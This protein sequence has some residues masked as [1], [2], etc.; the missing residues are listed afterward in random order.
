MNFSN[1]L[2]GHD[3][4]RLNSNRFILKVASALFLASLFAVAV[5]AAEAEDDEEESEIEMTELEEVIVTGSRLERNPGEIAGQ[6]IVL[7]QDAIRAMGE[8]TLERVL[9]QVPQNLNPTSEQFGQRLNTGLN[10]SGASTVNLRGLGSESTLILID[11]KRAGYSGFLGGVTDV[12]KIPLAQVERIEIVLDGASAIYGSDAVGGVVNVITRKDYEGIEAVLNYDRPSTAGY[13]ETRSGINGRTV[14]SGQRLSGGIQVATH[15]GLDASDRDVTI[16]QQSAFAGPRY[17]VRFCC[18]AEGEA[19]PIFYRLGGNAITL[20]EYNALDDAQK[21]QAEAIR[22]VKLPEGFNES[23]SL[24]DITE[25]GPP[26]WG[27]ATQEG[28]SVLPETTRTSF[29]AGIGSDV[30]PDISIEAT[31][32]GENRETLNN[33]GYISYSGQ[34]LNGRNPYNPFARPVHLRGQRRDLPGPY[35]ETNSDSLDLNF[36][37]SG[38]I[39]EQWDWEASIGRTTEESDSSRYNNVNRSALTA[40][41]NSDGVSPITQFLRGETPE[42]CAEKGG[43]PFFGLC[44]IQLPPIPAVNPFGDISEFITEP[45]DATSSNRQ[46]RLQALIRGELFELPGGMAKAMVGASMENTS[47]DSMTEFQIGVVEQSPIGDVSSLN[48]ETERSNSAIFAEGALPL[49]SDSNAMSGVNALHLSLSLRRD[50]Y[51]APDVTFISAD[52]ERTVEDLPE[53]GTETTWGLGVVYEPMTA[54]RLKLNRQ[55]AFVAPQLNQLL[56]ESLQ[57]PSPPFRGIWLQ[58]PDGSIQSRSI[59]VIE[60]GNPNLVPETAVTD[61]FGVEIAPPF[62]PGLVLRSTYSDVEYVDRIGFISAFFID[63]NNLPSNTFYDAEEDIYLQER[64][65]VNVSSVNR[66]G[67]DFEL[68]WSGTNDLGNY[69]ISLKRSVINKYDYV[70]DPAIQEDPLGEKISVVGE[71]TGTTAI[72]V[73]PKNSTSATVTVE[74]FGVETS[75]DYTT[76][77]ETTRSLAGVTSE[78]SAPTLM[79]LTFSMPLTEDFPIPLPATIKGGRISLIINNLG[80]QFGETRIRNAAGMPL[81]QTGTDRSPLYGRTFNLGLNLNL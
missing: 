64:R 75:W 70:I 80:D 2:S 62:A 38:V 63:P 61:S 42:S 52:G 71:T 16:F 50:T 81:E 19:F 55:T 25:F 20:T 32:R 36:D 6:V 34:T 9:R 22:Y 67:V 24:N 40:G 41:M 66:S 72:G 53:A 15:T 65:W 28:Y 30:T 18:S 35:T 76:R 73:V 12:S 29:Y 21:S 7:D 37:V 1:Y 56:R 78:Y 77:S 23:S 14:V 57:G 47:L 74:L 69:N 45:V 27:P 54:L 26:N 49:V 43:T 59:L 4:F 44:R 60:G 11:G 46:L 58:N 31:I 79:D 8:V 33:R 48:T 17:D 51:R 39:N 13:H 5:N 10:L 3:F 68:L